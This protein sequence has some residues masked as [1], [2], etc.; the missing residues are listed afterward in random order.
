M[1]AGRNRKVV[2]KQLTMRYSAC[3]C[4]G[5]KWYRCISKL[6]QIYLRWCIS[7]DMQENDGFVCR[8]G[9]M[10]EEKVYLL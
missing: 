10:T 8:S 5:K 6:K 7:L 9:E 2:E 3:V 4:W 1:E